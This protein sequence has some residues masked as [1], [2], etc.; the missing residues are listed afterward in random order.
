MPRHATAVPTGLCGTMLARL[1]TQLH[2]ACVG[3]TTPGMGLRYSLSARGW[4]YPL[5][6]AQ[7]QR[8]W[9]MTTR[10]PPQLQRRHKHTLWHV[11]NAPGPAHIPTCE[12]GLRS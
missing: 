8:G 2:I 1:L 4:F 6:L 7:A 10:R 9:R 5:A 11:C 12:I 3:P